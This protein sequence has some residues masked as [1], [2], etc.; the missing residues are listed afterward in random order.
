VAGAPPRRAEEPRR[1]SPSRAAEKPKGDVPPHQPAIAAAILIC[2]SHLRFPLGA[3]R[4]AQVVTGSR[5]KDIVQWRLDR[6][7]A[8]A[9]V[10]DGQ[11]AVKKVIADL[12]RSGHLKRSGDRTRPVLALTERGQEAAEQEFARWVSG[13]TAQG[14]GA[15]APPAAHR[16]ARPPAASAPARPD[17]FAPAPAALSPTADLDRCVG[18]ML[19]AD[20]EEA[21]GL[22][23]SLR[24]YHPAEI[25]ARLEARFGESREVRVQSRAVWAAGELCGEHALAF[26]VRCAKSD[27]GNVRRLTAS[28][29]GKVAATAR[30]AGIAHTETMVQA[31]AALVALLHDT[32][33][34]VAQY[35]EKALARFAGPS[36]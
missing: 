24:L 2:V 7:P 5:E 14:T 26:L 12:I 18:R 28:A 31:Q 35:A 20:R 34:Q 22:V 8:Y 19:V 9:T 13:P 29:L 4:I 32:A 23:A 27:E 17:A 33:P 6:N 30:L 10:R 1:S 16:E 3:G 36:A 15:N 11:D 25:A 21:E